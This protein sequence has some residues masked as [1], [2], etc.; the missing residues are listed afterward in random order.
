M[1][2]RFQRRISI[3]PGVRLNL[4]MHGI[5]ASVGPRGASLSVGPRGVYAN[6]G[7]PGTGLSYRERIAGSS[8]S[9]RDTAGMT[10]R[11]LRTHERDLALQSASIEHQRQSAVFEGL[12]G[13]LKSRVRQAYDW[14]KVW[15][16]RGPYTP[17]EFV[18]PQRNWS[19]ETETRKVA[20]AYPL[21][22]WAVPTAVAAMTTATLAAGLPRFGALAIL[23]ATAWWVLGAI[24]ERK[25]VLNAQLASLEAEYQADLEA[26]REAHDQQET[27]AGEAW[28]AEE[29][30]RERIRIAIDREDYEALVFV[31]E[32]ELQNEAHPFPFTFDLEMDNVHTMT[33]RLTLPGIDVVPE[34]RTSLTKRGRLSTHEMTQRDRVGLYVD[35]CA[36]LALRLG[37]EAFRV[38]PCLNQFILFGQTTRPDPSTGHVIT[39]TA[40]H[41]ETSREKL[42]A[43]DLDNLDPSSAVAL[44]EGRFACDRRGELSDLPA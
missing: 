22:R 32:H 36:S 4:G 41:F 21:W 34:S 13:I 20:A 44:L 23:A 9:L 33:V 43:L 24:R 6:V 26:L 35:V 15:G 42:S 19:A 7:I 12:T 14:A 31:L 3:L 40:L 1:G 39:I 10:L 17:L 2:M 11:E 28:L 30:L 18:A 37:N 27:A 25:R 38:L 8:Q 29:R 16:P 5:S